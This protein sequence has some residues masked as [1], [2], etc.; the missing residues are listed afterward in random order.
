MANFAKVKCQFLKKKK[1][2]FEEEKNKRKSKFSQKKKKKNGNCKIF[3]AD[4]SYEKFNLISLFFFFKMLI[5]G[6]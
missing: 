1:S 2:I 4:Q 3:W 5:F 6:F